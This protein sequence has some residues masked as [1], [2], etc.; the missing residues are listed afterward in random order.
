MFI[1]TFVC[2][3]CM[4]LAAD[5]SRF[6]VAKP[7]P[8][9]LQRTLVVAGVLAHSAYLITEG[10]HWRALDDS[11]FANWRSWCLTGSWIVAVSYLV[12]I[13]RRPQSQTG[14]FVLPLAMALAGLSF[15]FPIDQ[16][17]TTTDATIVW[18]AIHGMLLLLGTVLVLLG[19]SAG[20]MYLVQARRLKN[21]TSPS[22]AIRLP[23]LE[24]L[25]RANEQSLLCSAALLF[26][27]LMAGIVLNAQ[28]HTAGGESLPWT[29]PAICVSA[30]LAVWLVAS[31]VFALLY[32]PARVSKKV[33]YLTV[34]SFLV[35]SATMA[36]VLFG[37]SEHTRSLPTGNAEG[38]VSSQAEAF[39]A[40]GGSPWP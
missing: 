12:L 11:L 6:F 24:W 23:S 3:Y 27:G 34:A 17:F 36:V 30:G 29:D 1:T 40:E 25:Q 32:K 14:L 2:C 28:R 39:V 22:S 4:S 35:L 5:I 13:F 38:P 20:L 19:F 18:S 33:A 26:C 10:I 15:V 37:P 16:R 9:F 7:A 31:F 21:K 8:L